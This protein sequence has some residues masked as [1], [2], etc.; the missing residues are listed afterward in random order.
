MFVLGEKFLWN[1]FVQNLKIFKAEVSHY[2]L[3]FILL[4]EISLYLFV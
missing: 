1:H 3:T 4:D 2:Q